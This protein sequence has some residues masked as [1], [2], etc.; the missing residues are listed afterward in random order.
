MFA[1]MASAQVKKPRLVVIPSDALMNKLGLL[2]VNDDMGQ[3]VYNPQYKKAFLDDDLKGC[4]AKIGEMFRDRQFPLTSLENELSRIQNKVAA[5]PVDIRLEI[6]YKITKQGPRDMLYFELTGIDNYSSKQ[7]AG[8]SGESAPAIGAS[9]I[10]LLQEAVLA[11]VDKF[12][13]DIQEYFERMLV[14]GRES[15]LFIQSQCDV[16]VDKAV[17]K[18]VENWLSSNC[19]KGQFSTDSVTPEDITVSQAMMPLFS[20]SGKA[21]AAS[22]FYA[23]LMQEITRLV[24]IKGY[25]ASLNRNAIESNSRG[26]SLGDCYIV[27]AEPSGSDDF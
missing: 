15:R 12:A 17:I 11:K 4:V 5:I 21:L 16:H 3:E 24:S 7:I 10:N 20:A 27:I 23:P 14:D 25:E 6:N 19:V 22:D 13:N 2:E 1:T 8:A 26:G 18:L 9:T